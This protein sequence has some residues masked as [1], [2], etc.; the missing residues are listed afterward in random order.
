MALKN[1]CCLRRYDEFRNFSQRHVAFPCEADAALTFLFTRCVKTTS[2]IRLIRQKLY[3]FY[4]PPAILREQNLRCWLAC[5]KSAAGKKTLKIASRSPA[6]GKKIML[7]ASRSSATYKKIVSFA[8]R[9]FAAYKKILW[10][11]PRNSAANN[12]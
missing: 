12:L 4:C 6:A 8:C 5:R 10:L 7:L 1:Y 3:Q 9:N 2:K 11:R